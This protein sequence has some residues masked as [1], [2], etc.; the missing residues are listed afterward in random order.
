LL[1]LFIFDVKLY[2]CKT[3]M[4]IIMCMVDSRQNIN[5]TFSSIW[6]FCRYIFV[7]I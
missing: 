1:K 2:S 5:N 4:Y 7:L 6:S 3:Y